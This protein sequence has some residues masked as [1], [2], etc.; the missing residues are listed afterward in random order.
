MSFQIT[1]GLKFINIKVNSRSLKSN[2]GNIDHYHIKKGIFNIHKPRTI[3]LSVHSKYP[4]S[5]VLYEPVHPF[6]Q[7]VSC[8]CTAAQ[9]NPMMSLDVI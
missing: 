4:G 5:N 8:H 2:D 6:Q 7:V 3:L 9:D 1:H